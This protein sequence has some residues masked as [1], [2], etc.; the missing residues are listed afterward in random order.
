MLWL[1]HEVIAFFLTLGF[2]VAV[3]LLSVAIG[4]ILENVF[5]KRK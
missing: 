5:D 4:T 2:F 3:L 1:L